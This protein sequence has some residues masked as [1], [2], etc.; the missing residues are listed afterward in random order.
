MRSEPIT[1][2]P[3]LPIAEDIQ[4]YAD[5]TGTDTDTALQ[6]MLK[7][8]LE[9]REKLAE[10]EEEEE[11]KKKKAKEEAEAGEEA[12]GEAVEAKGSDLEESDLEEISPEEEKA[13]S[14]QYSEEMQRQ[15]GG[16]L[17]YHHEEGMNWS[18]LSP[19]VLVGS[20]PQEPDDIDM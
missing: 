12:E 11:A 19:D 18:F 20:C 13:L 1:F 2:A 6:N 15:M 8:F 16:D 4:R 7:E 14:E 17:E 3:T 5:A 9:Y 10:L